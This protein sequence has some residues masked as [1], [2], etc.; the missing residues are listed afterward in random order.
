VR[1][2]GSL[3]AQRDLVGLGD[4]VSL[5]RSQSL[6]EPLSSLPQELERICGG[7]LRSGTLWTCAVLLDQ[8]GLKGCG[9]LIGRLQR[10]VNCPIPCG[11][12]NHASSISCA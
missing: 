10:M 7:A 11:V 8:V 4:V 1:K 6:A 3:I 12:L 5:N 9:D 2:N